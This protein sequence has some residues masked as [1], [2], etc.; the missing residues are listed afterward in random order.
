[1]SAEK[2]RKW[3]EHREDYALQAVPETYRKW[4]WFSLFGVIARYYNCNVF[5]RMGWRACS[6]IWDEE[7]NNWHALRHSLYRNYRVFPRE[8]FFRNGA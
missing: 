6:S 4:N 3:I 5:P 7:F 8:S 1:M 2:E